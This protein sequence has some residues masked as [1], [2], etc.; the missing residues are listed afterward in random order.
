[1]CESCWW[2]ELVLGEGQCAMGERAEWV[3][4]VCRF[5]TNAGS[6]FELAPGTDKFVLS[7]VLKGALIHVPGSH[8]RE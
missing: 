2:E 7:V 3:D 6:K 1:M 5:V 4:A 8:L